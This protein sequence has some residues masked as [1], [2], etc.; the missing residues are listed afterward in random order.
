MHDDIHRIQEIA[1]SEIAAA[2]GDR[3]S[4]ESLRVKY[5]GR[6]GEIA[7]LFKK[8][9][10]VGPQERS[11]FGRLMNALKLSVTAA[12]DGA[13]GS[14]SAAGPDA[15][16]RTDVTLPGIPAMVGRLHP[17]TQTIERISQIFIGLGFRVVEGPEIETER[18]N[19][20]ALNIP[21]EHPSRDAFDTIYLESSGGKHL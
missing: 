10:D 9:S 17:I 14:A 2:K 13:L 8:I 20:E 3:G 1:L 5:L 12:I 7:E 21:L 11:E 18:Y 16:D 6:K 4:L 15:R 19:F